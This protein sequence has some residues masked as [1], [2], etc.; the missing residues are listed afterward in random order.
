MKISSRLLRTVE[1]TVLMV[2]CAIP[3][4]SAKAR[5]GSPGISSRLP[6]ISQAE[7]R[8]HVSR[9]R[10]QTLSQDDVSSFQ[11]NVQ[12]LVTYLAQA[13]TTNPNQQALVNDLQQQLNGLTP[14]EMSQMASSADV[15][16]FNTAVT[17][18]FSTQP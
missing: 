15:N 7:V 9:A 12:S 14:D 8:K 13:P 10:H 1:L 18:L 4:A 5:F 17:T 6:Q 11:T 2:L 3:L 16:A